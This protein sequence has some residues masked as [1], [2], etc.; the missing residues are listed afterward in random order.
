MHSNKMKLSV[1]MCLLVSSGVLP[2][3][4]QEVVSLSEPNVAVQSTLVVSSPSG[5]D[6]KTVGREPVGRGDRDTNSQ[7][8]DVVTDVPPER[9]AADGRSAVVR[10]LNKVLNL[11]EKGKIWVTEDP[12]VITPNLS[13]SAPSS[14][15]FSD[16][17]VAEPVLFNVYTNYAPFIEKAE[18]LVYAPEDVDRTK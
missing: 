13:V 3:Y 4:A 1:L 9:K 10:P 17:K 8:S 7:T 5:A 12:A 18:V 6:G 11:P 15:G 14:V 16:G 2:G